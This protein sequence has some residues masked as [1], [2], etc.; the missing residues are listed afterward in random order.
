VDTA[1]LRQI[2]AA[3]LRGIRHRCCIATDKSSVRHEEATRVEVDE[4][5]LPY[6]N[7]I[8]NEIQELLFVTKFEHWPYEQEI[9]VIVELEK[10]V[11]EGNR[12]GIVH[13]ALVERRTA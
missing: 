3:Y 2:E 13:I 12:D 9:R 6:G 8:P 7:T 10:A 5:V 11:R 1:D 4:G